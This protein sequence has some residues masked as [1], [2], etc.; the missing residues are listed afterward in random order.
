MSI[1]NRIFCLLILILPA[2]S[3][4]VD[5]QEAF[6][7]LDFDRPVDL[8]NAGDS[9]NRLFIVLQSG[10][11]RSFIND[12][13][14]A[15]TD[16]YLDIRDR[17]EDGGNEQGL[18]GLAFHP[19][20]ASNGYFFVNYTRESDGATVVSRF[21]EVAGVANRNSEVKLLTIAQPFSNH[22]GGALTFGNDGYLYIATGDGGSGG[23]PGNRAQNRKQLLGKVLR[24]DVDRT[25]AS[26]NYAIPSDNP[27]VRERGAKKQI[28]AYGFRNPWRMSVD[29]V[30]GKLWLGD[31]GQSS[32][33]EVDIVRK[34]G[35]YGWRLYEG[36]S[37]YDCTGAVC[38]NT[39]TIKPVFQ[40]DRSQ[41]EAITGGYVY[42]GNAVPSLQGFYV[43]ADYG[44]GKIF[45]LPTVK[46]F[47]A[48]IV[49]DSSALI[50][51]FG[52]DQSGELYYLDL[53]RGK[54]MKFTE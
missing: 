26:R 29:R 2:I 50:S 3:Y 54:I 42:H 10:I 14:I 24:I 34:G 45:K 52:V 21:Q 53:L 35:N 13:N 5:V 49:K 27:F 8:Q 28:F 43:F 22:N 6:P 9:S 46:P 16:E 40:Y 17:V 19:N 1:L 18:L 15:T 7:N 48:S 30:T 32:F 20:F 51:A 4:A 39:K 47:T 38:K 33:E 11:I 37:K 31:V 44:S 41:G 36:K 12:P 23:D 25:T